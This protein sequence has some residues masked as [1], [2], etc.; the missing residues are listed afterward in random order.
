MTLFRIL[1]L[2]I[3]SEA[4]EAVVLPREIKVETK[5]ELIDILLST[6]VNSYA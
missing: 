5:R 3:A 6:L 4:Y 1:F 2:Q